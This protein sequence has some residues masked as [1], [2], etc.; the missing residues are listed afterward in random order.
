MMVGNS[1]KPDILPALRAGGWAV[2]VP[3]ELTWDYERAEIPSNSPRFIQLP[4]I[5]QLSDLVA[6]RLSH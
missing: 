2:F 1:L 3:R 4:C 6:E 5:R